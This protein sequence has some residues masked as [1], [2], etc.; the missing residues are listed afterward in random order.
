MASSDEDVERLLSSRIATPI[1]QLSP[2]LPDQAAQKIYGEITIT[3]PYS[4]VTKVFAFLLAEPDFRLRRNKGLVRIQLKGPSAEAVGKWELGSGDEVTLALD[5]VEWAKDD[6]P[7]RP[8]GSRSDWQLK[9]AGKLMLKVGRALESLEGYQLTFSQAR[10]G[11]TQETKF[12]NIDQ[13]IPIETLETTN[14]IP[15]A[16]IDPTLFDAP[17]AL[18]NPPAPPAPFTDDEY[19]SP[20]FMKRSRASFGPLFEL[21]FEDEL[22]DDGGRKGKGRKRPRYSA[23]NGRWKLNEDNGSPEPIQLEGAISVVRQQDE[24]VEMHDTPDRP[25]MADGGVQTNES[26]LAPVPSSPINT[27]SK[28]WIGKNASLSSDARSPRPYDAFR[29]DSGIQAS[30]SQSEVPAP[31]EYNEKTTTTSTPNPFAQAS[32]S[33][34]FATSGL[35]QRSPQNQ[36]FGN[37]SSLFS[38]ASAAPLNQAFGGA[39]PVG[40]ASNRPSSPSFGQVSS[41]LGTALN[42]PANQSLEQT[43]SLFG[44]GTAPAR[45]PFSQTS[46]ADIGFG[47]TSGSLRFGFGQE[48]QSTLGTS[49]LGTIET[50]AQSLAVPNPESSLNQQVP[51]NS[52]PS[53]SYNPFSAQVGNPLYGHGLEAH[54]D[55]TASGDQTPE[56]NLPLWTMGTHDFDSSNAVGRIHTA[57]DHRLDETVS[58]GTPPGVIPPSVED[59]TRE[60]D[61]M[62]QEGLLSQ[63]VYRQ[64]VPQEA[65]PDQQDASAGED[66]NSV[67]SDERADYDDAEKGD[68]YDLRNYDRM[69]DDEEG[70]EDGEPLSDDELLDQGSEHWAGPD[71]SYEDG[72]YDDEEEDNEEYN[73]YPPAQGLFTQ[74]QVPSQLH[75]QKEKVVIDLLSDSDDDETPAPPV[76]APR[77]Q[78]LHES[79]CLPTS[80]L[81]DFSKNESVEEYE[82][83]AAQTAQSEPFVPLCNSTQQ[84]FRAHQGRT[85]LDEE[86][87]NFDDENGEF[88]DEERFEDDQNEPESGSELAESDEEEEAE[89]E[90]AITVNHADKYQQTGGFNGAMDEDDV[91][92]D[93][94]AYE[95][96][97]EAELKESTTVKGPNGTDREPDSNSGDMTLN[98]DD[99]QRDNPAGSFQTQPDEMLAS[100]QFQVAT[101]T[102]L[103]QSSES[104]N[105]SDVDMEDNL[106][107]EDSHSVGNSEPRHSASESDRGDNP[108]RDGMEQPTNRDAEPFDIDSKKEGVEVAATEIT[109]VDDQ[110]ARR[111]EVSLNHQDGTSA[112]PTLQQQEGLA[113]A[114]SAMEISMSGI[115]SHIETQSSHQRVT[116]ET[117]ETQLEAKLVLSKPVEMDVHLE[118]E[119][120]REG[121][122]K[123]EEEEEEGGQMADSEMAGEDAGDVEPASMPQPPLEQD[124]ERE[125][126]VQGFSPSKGLQEPQIKEIG[127]ASPP[128]VI[129]DVLPDQAADETRRVTAQIQDP[130]SDDS[131]EFHEA[132][133]INEQAIASPAAQ[134]EDS[135]ASIDSHDAEEIEMSPAK[136]KRGGKKTPHAPNSKSAQSTPVSQKAQ[137]Q[138]SRQSSRQSSRQVSAQHAPSSQRTTR[139]KAMSF[140]AASPKEDKEDMSI[141]LARAALKSPM[142]KKRK[143]SATA[144]KRLATDLTK[145]LENDLPDCV[146]LSNLRKYN[147]NFVD[148]AAVATSANVPPKR[149]PTREYASS[150]TITDPSFAPDGVAE[151]DLYSL[152]KDHLPVVKTGDSVLLRGFLV[153]SLPGRGFGLK[154][155]DGSAWAVFKAEGGNEPEMKAATVEMNKQE[156]DFML[157]SRAWY[158]GLD[159]STKGKLVEAVGEMVET[160]KDSRARK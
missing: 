157:D 57:E 52:P 140:Q 42:V 53:A 68:D 62:R 101:A 158:A 11:E 83:R 41:S 21:D 63:P 22:E 124:N 126:E 86:A 143:G 134:L 104:H 160:G 8:A 98:V 91:Q 27:P 45:L 40:N 24:D 33:F 95:E 159:D 65:L 5:G 151:V 74:S 106:G 15:F 137:R 97:D 100:F 34:G 64:G 103:S 112:S 85:D 136:P 147:A 135:F 6:E 31:T 144:A 81:A 32:Q 125:D 133:E 58:D 122:V 115:T 96:D 7:V 16:E 114:A 59:R 129:A 154:S 73:D 121:A 127:S 2:D 28:T 142:S 84:E 153:V 30:P 50:S 20:M 145:R 19:A 138:P 36:G 110:E 72:D 29:T 67:D 92:H 56:Q 131:E 13:P 90:E 61:A 69:S 113:P 117:Q 4:S 102:S 12:V 43:S 119:T 139:S 9:F 94:L 128:E 76:K 39:F 55:Q 46:N 3:W 132:L 35:T 120:D 37:A 118:E 75:V 80:D 107:Q 89:I 18:E 60:V 108:E 130:H 25:E 49:R 116:F 141:Q 78:T 111:A 70:F 47:D 54:V 105:E 79:A 82:G 77:S 14:P 123:E 152:H 44:M 51:S 1:A 148:V 146:C 26:D 23:V 99:V 48:P 38:M 66:D 88:S 93:S 109:E 156:T 17:P 71:A 149:T 150:F 155:K 10:L 87:R